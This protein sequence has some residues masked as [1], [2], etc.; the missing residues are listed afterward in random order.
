MDHTG[1]EHWQ[2]DRNDPS[3]KHSAESEP[4]KNSKKRAKERVFIGYRYMNYNI[5]ACI[6]LQMHKK[7]EISVAFRIGLTFFLYQFLGFSFRVGCSGN[8]GEC[9][10][11]T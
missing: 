4:V 6:N 1:L 10:R 11:N 3:W 7:V 9:F 5:Y 8:T 2:E